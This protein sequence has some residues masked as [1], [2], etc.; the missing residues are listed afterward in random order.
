MI[1]LSV[2]SIHN[3]VQNF[4][5]D[6]IFYLI[7]KYSL[8][9]KIWLFH[10]Y[11]IIKFVLCLKDDDEEDDDMPKEKEQKDPFLPFPKG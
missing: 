4:T 8:Q 1:C 5:V 11:L 9:N 6:C 2:C 3:W 7:Y 10:T